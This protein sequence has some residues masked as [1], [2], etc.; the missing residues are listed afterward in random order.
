MTK[1][2]PYDSAHLDLFEQLPEDIK[3]FGKYDSQ[4]PFPLGEYGTNFTAVANGQIL[5]VG[6]VLQM[7][8]R[9]G[10]CWTMLSK[11]GKQK[12][13]AAFLT[14]K[15]QLE[16]LMETMNLHRVE[17]ANLKEATEHHEWCRLLGFVEEGEMPLYD[18]QGRT[19]IGF[20]KY[21]KE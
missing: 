7:S 14:V 16:S 1:L 21:R 10:K 5:V 8:L 17:T 11:Y 15:K 12:P 4:T 19:Y 3:R 18:D 20:A 6:G 2:L 13:I 9:T